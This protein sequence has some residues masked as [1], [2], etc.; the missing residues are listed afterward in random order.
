MSEQRQIVDSCHMDE[1]AENRDEIC[2]SPAY[3]MTDFDEFMEED[4]ILD[5]KE[6]TEM[7]HQDINEVISQVCQ[8]ILFPEDLEGEEDFGEREDQSILFHKDLEREEDFGEREDGWITDTTSIFSEESIRCSSSA[9]FSY[10]YAAM[11]ETAISVVSQAIEKAVKTVQSTDAV[12]NLEENEA[13]KIV[14]STESFQTLEN[15]EVVR[16]IKDSNAPQSRPSSRPLG[17]VEEEQDI[18]PEDAVNVVPA[19]LS[20]SSFLPAHQM[21]EIPEAERQLLVQTVDQEKVTSSPSHLFQDSCDGVLKGFSPGPSD[22]DGHVALSQEDKEAVADWQLVLNSP[23]ITTLIRRFF[24]SLDDE[25]W[26]EVSEG[27]Y[28]WNVKEQLTDMCTDLLKFISESVA[29]KVLQFLHLRSPLCSVNLTEFFGI[30]EYSMQRCLESSFSQA[31]SDIVGADNPGVISPKFT[32]DMA[33]EITDELNSILSVAK[34]ASLE[35][36]SSSLPIPV[37]CLVSKDRAAKKTLEGAISTMKS[38]LTGRGITVKRRIHRDEGSPDTNKE[39]TPARG[40]KR[41]RMKSW[42]RWFRFWSRNKTEPI[43]LT[44]SCEATTSASSESKSDLNNSWSYSEETPST[45]SPHQPQPD[46]EVLDDQADIKDTK[47]KRSKLF[48]FGLLTKASADNRTR[49]PPLWTK[50]LP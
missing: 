2:S 8:S 47:S 41:Q 12:K 9:S 22:D 11:T 17:L 38:F 33:R 31:L 5:D 49:S 20:T 37:S 29:Q 40:G 30:T 48:L 25:Q 13:E 26:R 15:T 44:N 39:E 4:D 7:L 45:T 36:E 24:Q 34:Q 19:P 28:N 3:S 27:V 32:E 46:S 6:V 42:K 50:F 35:S 18:T 21:D 23:T 1:E 14:Q 10:S 43:P 16:T